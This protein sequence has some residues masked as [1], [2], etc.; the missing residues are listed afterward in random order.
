MEKYFEFYP[1]RVP[2]ELTLP[3]TTLI[4]NL[5]ISSRRYPDKTA[6]NYY[7]KKISYRELYSEVLSLAGYLQANNVKK[8]DRVLLYMQNSPQW[9]ISFYAVARA[10]AVV[11]PI[12]P[13]NTSEELAFY[14][15]DCEI[16]TA[17]VSQEL[18]ENVRALMNKS[19]IEHVVVGTYSDYI[20]SEPN[21]NLPQEVCALRQELPPEYTPWHEAL[22]ARYSPKEVDVSADDLVVMPYTS[23][24]TGTPKGCMHTHKTVQ[25]NIITVGVWQSV[26]SESVHLL[27]LPLFHVTGMLHSCHGPLSGGCEIVIMTRWD[28]EL[29]R[30]LIE[31]NGVTHWT[32]IST[33]LIDFLA[34]PY[35]IKDSLKTLEVIGGGGA[36]LPEAVGEKLY[37]LAGIRYAE[38]YG[39]SETIAHTHFNPPDR[40][41]LQCLGIPSPNT[42]SKII[43]PLTL[44]ELGPNQEGEIVVRGPQV[45]KGYYNRPEENVNAFI[46]IE[47]KTFFRTGDIAKYDDEGYYFIVDRIKRMINASGFKVWPTEVESKLYRHPAV[48]QACV[49]GVPDERKGEQVKA[50]IVLNEENKGKVTEQDII[51]WSKTQLAAYK[52]PRVIEFRDKLPTTSSGKLLW[53]KLQEEERNK[54]VAGG[55]K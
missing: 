21:L 29:A 46:T 37:N 3:E 34:N 32:N 47:G 36:P 19:T 48:Q 18:F 49:V 42:Q 13:M 33:M 28:R 22:S 23:G 16:K 17:I 53:R 2:K 30:I 52:Y 26:T 51:D 6:L 4:E 10:G 14:V 40:P 54:L 44:Q 24:T 31:R 12:N 7:G 55:E 45:F 20:D 43:D 11:I 38:G 1:K 9:I 15:K 25:A 39:L 50:F 5:E 8:G 41:K 35:L 27:T